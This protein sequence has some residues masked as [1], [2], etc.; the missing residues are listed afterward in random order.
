[1]IFGKKAGHTTVFALTETGRVTRYEVTVTRQVAEIASALKRAV[2]KAKVE[3][4]SAPNGITVSGS[5]ESPRD[6]QKLRSAATQFLGEKDSL[7]FNVAVPASTQVN[8]RV[9]VAEVS[10]TADKAF[11]FNW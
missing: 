11:G 9:R 4:S 5:A 3:V 8:L 6:T 1:V 2:P 7:N 10:R